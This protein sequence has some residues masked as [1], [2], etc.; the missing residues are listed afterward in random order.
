MNSFIEILNVRGAQF[1]RFAWPMLWQSSLLIALLFALD[2]ALRKRVRATVRYVLWMLVVV[3]LVL[4]ASLSLPTGVGYW[5]PAPESVAM[6][7]AMAPPLL[8]HSENPR[9]SAPPTATRLPQR[10]AVVPRAVPLPA[11]TWPGIVAASWFCCVV[12]LTMIFLLRAAQARRIAAR[13]TATDD[14]SE[15]LSSCARKMRV[16]PGVSLRLSDAVNTPAVCGVFRPVILLPRALA[17]KLDAPQMRAVLLH[18]LA[19]IRRGDLWAGHL[20]TTLQIFYFYNPFLW[21]ANAAIRRVREEAVDELVLVAMAEEAAVYPETLLNVAKFS[22]QAPRLAFGFAGILEGKSTLGARIR[23]ML[24]RP[25]P[26][27][28][29]LGIPA[30]L[31]LL[32][33]GLILLPMGYSNRFNPTYQD[34]EEGIPKTAAQWWGQMNYDQ[35]NYKFQ[36]GLKAFV[37]LGKRAVPFLRKELAHGKIRDASGPVGPRAWTPVEKAALI[38]SEMGP[39][40]ASAVPDLIAV[41]KENDAPSVWASSALA[42]AALGSIGPEARAAVPALFD[43]LQNSNVAAGEALVQIDPDNPKLVP[44]V[45]DA[46]QKLS[47]PRTPGQSSR[48]HSV[49]IFRATGILGKLGPRAA[50]AIPVLREMLQ[51]T[52]NDP[53]TYEY[54]YGAARALQA[55]AADQPEIVAEANAVLQRE[56]VF[57]IA[58]LTAAVEKARG[59]AGYFDAFQKL[60]D[61]V[62]YSE[63]HGLP[64][65]DVLLKERILPLYSE[66]LDSGNQRIVESVISGLWDIGSNAAPLLP[67]V[68]KIAQ[69]DDPFRES[70]EVEIGAMTHI[71]PGDPTT[72]PIFLRLVNDTNAPLQVRGSVCEALAY[73]GPEAAAAVPGLHKLLGSHEIGIR[74]ETTF[75]LW[76]IAKEPPSVKIL[77]EA[78]SMDADDD[79][80]Y[81]SFRTLEMLGGLN[82]QTDETKSIIRQ[83]A[84]SSSA[85]VR[86]NALALLEKIGEKKSAP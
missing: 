46:L 81:F 70:F 37:H 59:T 39:T 85:E 69:Q 83:L 82:A 29:K 5:V 43:A 17:G 30:A 7:E 64:L 50:A 67:K 3:K 10:A 20:Q 14:F 18:E 66:A 26:T 58:G 65:S 28:A 79:G 54:R 9:P 23:L 47:G 73:F 11:L 78:I 63:E 52:N 61:S 1:L 38:L 40:A 56:P 41:V 4:P 75:D 55:I 8:A 48:N 35:D 74:F 15:L 72:L 45:L 27:S 32:I 34:P 6:E 33:L 21:L 77:Q 57:D 36:D 51:N 49:L 44:A 12:V 60:R 19:H 71:A 76:R 31:A 2:F 25:W 22:L 84:Q 86:T 42:A 62:R 80:H 68:I 24:Q 16:R 13:A 53:D